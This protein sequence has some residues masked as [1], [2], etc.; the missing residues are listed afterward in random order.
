MGFNLGNLAELA[1]FPANRIDSAINSVQSGVQSASNLYQQGQ[2]LAQGLSSGA[3]PFLNNSTVGLLDSLSSG[4]SIGSATG[5]GRTPLISSSLNP[6][7]WLAKAKNRPD[8]L[9]EFSWD[10]MLVGPLGVLPHEYIEDVTVPLPR[11]DMSHVVMQSSKYYY[12]STLDYGTASLKLYETYR[13]DCTRYIT[14]WGRQI[15]T[16]NGDYEVPSR[17]KG[18]LYVWIKDPANQSNLLTFTM[19]G[20]FP[21]TPN[22]MTLGSQ[23]HRIQL[24]LELA[25]DRVD[26]S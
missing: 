25:I 13:A 24:D 8:P 9:F 6:N 22:G 15:R 19:R 4:E 20:A 14:N 3:N 7:G 18:L 5:S 21:T 16:A 23:G 17:Y 2:S 1:G 12:A 10:A 11:F 26:I